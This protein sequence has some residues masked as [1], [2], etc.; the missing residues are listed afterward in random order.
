MP[1]RLFEIGNVV[2]LDPDTETRVNESR[3]LGAIMM[4][5][6]IGYAEARA[7]LDALLFELGI[8]GTYRAALHPTFIEGRLAEIRTADC[9]AQAGEIHPQV[10]NNMGVTFPV[11]YLELFLH[12]VF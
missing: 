9:W 12:R 5:P 1:I 11:A 7:T 3:H 10:L 8:D 2:T 4:G 6:E